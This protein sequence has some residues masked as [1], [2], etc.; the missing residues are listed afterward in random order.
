VVVKV[1]LYVVLNSRIG[2]GSKQ[3]DWAWSKTVG[4]GVVVNSRIS[5]GGKLSDGALW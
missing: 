5:L 4:L 1:G 3:S 2:R